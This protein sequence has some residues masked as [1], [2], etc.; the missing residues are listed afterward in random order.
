MPTQDPAAAPSPCTGICSLD[1]ATGW[2][3][4]CGRTIGEIGEW[5]DAGE[6]RKAAILA[7]LDDRMAELRKRGSAAPE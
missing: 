3:A 6:P 7:K 4:G 5:R 2:C 1:P